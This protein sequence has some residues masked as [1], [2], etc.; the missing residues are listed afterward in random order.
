MF[1]AYNQFIFC[2]RPKAESEENGDGIECRVETVPFMQE[3]YHEN[4]LSNKSGLY[5]VVL[6]NTLC[7]PYLLIIIEIFNRNGC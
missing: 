3:R 5:N 4:K 6:S 2:N 1:T 7:V